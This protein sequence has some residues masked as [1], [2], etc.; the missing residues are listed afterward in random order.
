MLIMFEILLLLAL[1]ALSALLLSLSLPSYL[2]LSLTLCHYLSLP[3]SLLLPLPLSLSFALSCFRPVS[4]RELKRSLPA[5]VLRTQPFSRQI[6]L[7]L[8]YLRLAKIQ[9]FLLAKRKAIEK[10]CFRIKVKYTVYIPIQVYNQRTFQFF[11]FFSM[12]IQLFQHVLPN[13]Q[14]FNACQYYFRSILHNYNFVRFVFLKLLDRIISQLYCI[15][16]PLKTAL[17]LRF[18]NV[19]ITVRMSEVYL[20]LSLSPYLSTFRSSLSL[21]QSTNLSLYFCPLSPRHFVLLS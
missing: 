17:F 12:E 20:C 14:Q 18:L 11:S 19:G 13:F 9:Y 10:Y 15:V 6:W 8:T 7:F 21:P 4:N 16:F 5:A 3:L 2:S 1:A